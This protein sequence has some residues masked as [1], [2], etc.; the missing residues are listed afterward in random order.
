MAKEIKRQAHETKKH[1]E[2]RLLK[3]KASKAR[4]A[5]REKKEIKRQAHETKKHFEMRLQKEKAAK[6]AHGEAK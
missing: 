3:E 4:A 2:K 5:R 1:F 6:A